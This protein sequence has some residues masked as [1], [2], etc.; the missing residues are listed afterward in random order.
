ME[1][2]FRQDLESATEVVLDER[3]RSPRLRTGRARPGPMRMRVRTSGARALR[4]A[5]QIGSTVG[6]AVTGYRDL[7]RAEAQPL[8]VVGSV[9]L[10]LAL[11]FVAFPWLPAVGLALLCAWFAAVTLVR[12]GRALRGP[13]GGESPGSR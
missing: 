10:V 4:G 8:L 12:A 11:L 9:L 2:M 3:R 1:E 5:A 6:A 7:G 13:K